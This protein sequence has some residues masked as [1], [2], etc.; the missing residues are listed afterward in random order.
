MDSHYSQPEELTT[1]NNNQNMGCGHTQCHFRGSSQCKVRSCKFSLT[2]F[3]KKEDG[4]KASPET[5]FKKFYLLL[6][7]RFVF[8]DRSI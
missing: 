7:I 4:F 5:I 8:K 2:N 1:I 6:L 3:G